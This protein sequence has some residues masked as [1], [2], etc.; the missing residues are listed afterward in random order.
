MGRPAHTRYF[1]RRTFTQVNSQHS[2]F[3]SFVFSSYF[4]RIY[5][6]IRFCLHKNFMFTIW[7]ARAS[8]IVRTLEQFS[9]TLAFIYYFAYS[10]DTTFVLHSSSNE[11]ELR[12]MLSLSLCYMRAFTLLLLH[13]LVWRHYVR[14]LVFGC[15]FFLA[16]SFVF[17]TIFAKKWS[18][19]VAPLIVFGQPHSQIS[20]Q[21]KNLKSGWTH[22][23]SNTPHTHTHN[24]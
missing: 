8:V 3:L 18:T 13:T 17:Q 5:I 11:V 7:M 24:R 1:I 10:S 16:L 14:T 21:R 9:P 23:T 20:F 15:C 19:T 6:Y 2:R 22:L 4:C 12:K